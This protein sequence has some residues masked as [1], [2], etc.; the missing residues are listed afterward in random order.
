MYDRLMETVHNVIE[1][2]HRGEFTPSGNALKELEKLMNK[3]KKEE[4]VPALKKVLALPDTLLNKL[5]EEAGIE[6]ED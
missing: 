5:Y 4:I 1:M 2:A 3:F 6:R